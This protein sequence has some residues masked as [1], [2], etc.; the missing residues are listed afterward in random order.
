MKKFFSIPRLVKSFG[1]ALKGI[2]NTFAHEANA[3]IHLLAVVVVTAAGFYF[4]ISP[5]EWLVQ[6]LVMGAVVAAE[7]F[8]TAI[9][10]LVDLLHPEYDPKAG[11]IKD[12]AAGA[13]LVLAITAI[14]IAY[15]IYWAK[16]MALL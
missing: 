12:I 8:N 16:I 7:L 15:Q 1:Y 9:E 4:S 14:V 6:T 11:A 5:T 10:K 3:Q 2:V 13:V